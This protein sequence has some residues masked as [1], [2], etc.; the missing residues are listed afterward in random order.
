[1]IKTEELYYDLLKQWCGALVELQLSDA[2][3]ELD[4]GLWC[5]ACGGMHGTQTEICL[6]P[7]L[8]YEEEGTVYRTG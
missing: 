1:M 2:D 4:G 3:P 6:S 5:P 7:R 8:E